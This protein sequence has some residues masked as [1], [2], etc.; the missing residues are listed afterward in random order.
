VVSHGYRCYHL[1]TLE[2][3]GNS[4]CYD[5]PWSAHQSPP[6]ASILK[7]SASN[8]LTGQFCSRGHQGSTGW[9]RLMGSPK[10]QIIFHKR[11]IKYRSL[12]RR[13]TCKEKGSY[14]SSPPCSVYRPYQMSFC[15][16]VL[17]CTESASSEYLTTSWY[18]GALQGR[19]GRVKL[20]VKLVF[21]VLRCIKIK[22]RTYHSQ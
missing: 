13:M 2:N 6:L 8:V 12:L 19:L 18:L 9:R 21:D 15:E 14:E 4:L 3:I 16:Q 1:F 20:V 17:T 7:F 11:A 5:T 10:L 22:Q